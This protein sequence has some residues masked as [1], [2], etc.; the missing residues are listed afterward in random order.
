MRKSPQQRKV[1][2]WLRDTREA[3][4]MTQREFAAHI[5][6]NAPFVTANFVAK[7]ELGERRLDVVEFVQ[8]CRALGSNPQRMFAHLLEYIG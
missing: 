7:M 6:K 3:R 8:I 4:Q 5:R 2:E 1:A